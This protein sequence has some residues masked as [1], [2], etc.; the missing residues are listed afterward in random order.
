VAEIETLALN[1]WRVCHPAERS[2]YEGV[3]PDI[4]MKRDAATAMRFA[5]WRCSL[6]L[7]IMMKGSP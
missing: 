3:G 6:K 5:D 2:T 4:G 7:Q 1:Q